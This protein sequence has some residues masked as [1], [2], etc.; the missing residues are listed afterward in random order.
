[1][2]KKDF[3][4]KILKASQPYWG[5]VLD[6]ERHLGYNRAQVAASVL[7]TSI[8]LWMNPKANPNERRAAWNLFSMK[9]EK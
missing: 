4:T 6:G 9:S 7:N 5:M 3:S 8:E 2:T 1:M